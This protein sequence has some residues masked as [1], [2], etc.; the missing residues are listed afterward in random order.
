MPKTRLRSLVSVT[1][2]TCALAAQAQGPTHAASAANAVNAANTLRPDPLD[3]TAVVPATGY[4]SAFAR[5]RG[6]GD[7]PPLSWREANDAVARIGGWRAYA[8]EAQQSAPL[9][10][11]APEPAASK[12]ADTGKDTARPMAMPPGHSGHKSP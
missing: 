8:R 7:D 12:P 2:S 3:A 10:S 1:L 9:P 11:D 5:Y 6:L 4:H